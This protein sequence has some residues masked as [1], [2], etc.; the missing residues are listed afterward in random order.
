[1]LALNCDE[2]VRGRGLGRCSGGDA[3]RIEIILAPTVPLHLRETLQ[4]CGFVL[5]RSGSTYGLKIGQ[6]WVGFDEAIVR[7]VREEPLPKD[8]GGARSI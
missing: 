5:V 4:R 6:T 7:I 2:R 8:S 3:L 1:V